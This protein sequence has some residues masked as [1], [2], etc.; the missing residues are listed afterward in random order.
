MAG[1]NTALLRQLAGFKP[2]YLTYKN[3]KKNG[4]QSCRFPLQS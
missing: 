3:T 4:S 2:F 1:V